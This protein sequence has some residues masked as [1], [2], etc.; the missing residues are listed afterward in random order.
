MIIDPQIA[1]MTLEMK[2]IGLLFIIYYFSFSPVVARDVLVPPSDPAISYIGRMVKT[3][4][5]AYRF[6][7]PGTQIICAFEGTAIRMLTSPCSGY[8]MVQLDQAEPFKVSLAGKR[9]S[10]VTLAA[11]LSQGRHTLKVVYCIEGYEHQ[12]AFRGFLL[13]EGTTIATPPTLPARKI[14][15]IGN[16][17]TCGYGNEINNKYE[18][19]DFATENHYYSY[20]AIAARQLEAQAYIVARSGIGIY[21]NYSGP[22]AGNPDNNMPAEYEYTLYASSLQQRQ[23][24]PDF[25]QRWDFSQYQPDLVCI[26]LG[27]NDVSTKGYDPDS[28][29]RA[30]SAFLKTVRSH[31]PNA[32]IIFLCG[33]ML[34]G[35]ELTVARQTLDEVTTQARNNGD[36]RVHRF[37]FTPQAGDLGYGADW[38]PSLW[39]HQKMA[40]ELV[41]F[42][43]P[44]M[45]W[46]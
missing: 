6:N 25:R 24:T 30:Y 28:L 35:P 5:A 21:R 2:K 40:A 22:T 18:H 20:A 43:R 34:N 31:Y 1:Q 39:Q 37:D 32:H 26:N 29:K 19:F 45:Q 12:P 11:A 16:S 44:L 10:V 8:F 14:E 38:H 9:D 46:F 36:S 23:S 13:P 17:I 3:N 27:T 7:Y 33:S 4:P 15:F 41:S 42:V